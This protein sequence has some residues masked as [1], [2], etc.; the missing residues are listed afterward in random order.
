MA[1]HPY[2]LYLTEAEESM[3]KEFFPNM[4]IQIA[5]REVLRDSLKMLRKRIN[6]EAKLDAS[7]VKSV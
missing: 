2:T 1:G 6:R 3:I 4:P 7:E 5:A